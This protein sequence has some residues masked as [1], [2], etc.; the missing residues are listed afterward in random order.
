MVFQLNASGLSDCCCIGV[1]S[2]QDGLEATGFGATLA[3]TAVLAGV[4]GLGTGA[5]AGWAKPRVGTAS[6]HAS[7]TVLSAADQRG[8]RWM[9]QTISTTV[10][11]TLK[12]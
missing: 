7:A 4:A 5:G 2:L 8:A 12:P 1:S 10:P 11:I 3:G 9:K 6:T